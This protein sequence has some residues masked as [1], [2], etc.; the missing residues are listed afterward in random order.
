[1]IDKHANRYFSK[2]KNKYVLINDNLRLMQEISINLGVFRQSAI[3]EFPLVSV[4][5]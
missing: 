4:G 2:S 5:N 1:M 3:T